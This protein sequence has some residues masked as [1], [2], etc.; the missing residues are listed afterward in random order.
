MWRNIGRHTD[1]NTGRPVNQ[2]V[3]HPR[4][5]NG[6]FVFFFIVVELEIDSFFVDIGHQLM[7]QS[8]HTRFGVTHRCRGV[9]IDRTKVT[10]T[11]DQHVTQR[12]RLC[13]SH[14]RVVNCSVAMRVVFTDHVTDDTG[15]FVIR[16]IAMRAEFMHRE[17]YA[18]VNRF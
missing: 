11:I 8:R 13:H 7:C 16:L 10:L 5:H 15:R 3:R 14:Q 18:A 4:W 17:K 9:T 6:G 1:G 2:K 12:E